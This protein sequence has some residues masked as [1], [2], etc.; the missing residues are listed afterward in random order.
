M[1]SD[2]AKITQKT[3]SQFEPNLICRIRSARL[4]CLWPKS[5][6]PAVI[7]CCR[8]CS[9]IQTT[10]NHRASTLAVCYHCPVAKRSR[11]LMHQPLCRLILPA[12][13]PPALCVLAVPR[14][15]QLLCITATSSI[16]LPILNSHDRTIA[17]TI[18]SS[19][20]ASN[21]DSSRCSP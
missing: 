12:C 3:E 13:S 6:R 11:L 18:S 4:C 16:C 2:A 20:S 10:P 5:M 15:I 19:L 9:R 17:T 1:L 8:T 14:S 21:S 7:S